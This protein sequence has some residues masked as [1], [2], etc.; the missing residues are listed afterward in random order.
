MPSWSP[1]LRPTIDR[2]WLEREARTDPI[3]HA[4]ALWDL[5]RYPEQVRFVSAVQGETTVGYLLVWLGHPTTP[6]VHWFGASAD[7]RVL[8]E[9]LPSRPLIAI[10]PEEV[11]GD[12]ERARGPVDARSLLLLVAEPQISTTAESRITEVRSLTAADRPRLVALTSGRA[13][14]VASE[15]PQ[16]DPD[17][18]RIWGYFEGEELQGVARA[19]VRL[20]SVWL[21]GG[22]YVDPTERGRGRGLALVRTVL[23]AGQS[24]GATVALY[25][26]EDRP[27]AR[28]VYERAGFRLRSRRVWLG[29]GAALEP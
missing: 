4:Y 8:I 17:S 3:A 29:A 5:D 20:P 10:V 1:V 18:E 26:R 7:A 12:I 2:A 23:A 27:A 9:G 11:R 13:E 24:A 19:V 21:L 16:L 6:I 25:V 14:L 28:A 15:Y 22:V